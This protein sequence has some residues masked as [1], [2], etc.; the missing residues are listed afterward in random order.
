MERSCR[1]QVLMGMAA[2][3]YGELILLLIKLAIGEQQ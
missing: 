2:L 3:H 1:T